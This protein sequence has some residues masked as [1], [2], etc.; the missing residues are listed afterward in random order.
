MPNSSQ[1]SYSRFFWFW[2]GGEGLQNHFKM[3]IGKTKNNATVG[4]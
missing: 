4:F 3:M 2:A 1:K